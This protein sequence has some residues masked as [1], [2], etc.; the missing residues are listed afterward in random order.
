[1]GR[2][3]KTR[4]QSNNLANPQ[5]P[6]T[7]N[8]IGITLFEGL[9]ATNREG[10][11]EDSEEKLPRLALR[12]PLRLL[13]RNHSTSQCGTTTVQINKAPARQRRRCFRCG[14]S[15]SGARIQASRR[16][17][18]SWRAQRWSTREIRRAA[19]QVRTHTGASSAAQN[20]RS[21]NELARSSAAL[22]S[23]MLTRRVISAICGACALAS[24]CV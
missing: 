7:S 21:A 20:W 10:I 13:L 1:M 8:M 15:L 19:E 11:D 14:W 16:S 6:Q 3:A 18:C 9:V 17:R 24:H 22:H 12:L 23:R 5:C 2:C 4:L